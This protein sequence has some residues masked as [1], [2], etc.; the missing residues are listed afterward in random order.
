MLKKRA[1]NSR[2]A[3]E[4]DLLLA[5]LVLENF[6]GKNRCLVALGFEQFKFLPANPNTQ[7]EVIAEGVCLNLIC[8]GNPWN[9]CQIKIS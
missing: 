7:K 3:V 4:R 2:G 8:A 9:G 6:A 1:K 5:N